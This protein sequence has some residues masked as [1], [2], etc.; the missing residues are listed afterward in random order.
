MANFRVNVDKAVYTALNV[1]AVT[2]VASGGV[3][4]MLAPKG[5]TPPYVVFQAMSK[6]D[7]HAFALRGGNAVYMIKAIS[8]QPWPKE[9]LDVDTEV[10]TVMEDAVLSITGFNLLSCRREED[11]YLT[12]DSGGVLWHHVGGLYRIIA[13]ET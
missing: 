9:A 7:D 8:K 3:F 11:I 4:N 1:A 10:D 6:T 2:N 13:D 5:T 12:E